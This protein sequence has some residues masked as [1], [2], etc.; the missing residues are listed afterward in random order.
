MRLDDQG[1]PAVAGLREPSFEPRQ[2]ARQGRSDIGV[3]D[4]RRDPLVLLDLRQHLRGQRDV[5]AGQFSFDRRLGRELVPRVAVGVQV[6]DRDRLDLFPFQHVDGAIER[7]RIERRLDPAV[8]AQPL[9]HAEP[10]LARNQLFGRRQ[11]QIVAVVLQ[12][13]AHLDHV[14]MAFGRQQPDPRPLVFEQRIGRDRRPMNDPLGLGQQRR[15]LDPERF[16]QQLSPSRTPI[17]GS[18]GVEGTLA[19]VALPKSSTATRS[20][21]VPPTSTP[22]RYITKQP[23]TRLAALGTLSRSAGE[24]PQRS[25]DQALSRNAGEGGPSPRAGG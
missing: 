18:S 12:P 14:A 5:D 1:R 15:E 4:G 13:L 19:R 20:V 24:G 7:H 25:A 21:K 10:Q 8:G 16:R 6:A 3:D 23:L 9:A 22:M 11:A 17:E 2:I